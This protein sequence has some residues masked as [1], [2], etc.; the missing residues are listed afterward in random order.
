MKNINIKIEKSI[1]RNF[2]QDTYIT[3]QSRVG[4]LGGTVLEGEKTERERKKKR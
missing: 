4:I 3:A 2:H 1:R